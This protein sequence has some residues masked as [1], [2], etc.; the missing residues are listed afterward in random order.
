M[1]TEDQYPSTSDCGTGAEDEDLV[2][3]CLYNAL[4]RYQATPSRSEYIGDGEVCAIGAVWSVGDGED[5]KELVYSAVNIYELR[6]VE[7][8]LKI[9]EYLR[10]EALAAIR[11]LNAAALRLH[12]ECEDDSALASWT[13]P[14]EWVNQSWVPDLGECPRYYVDQDGYEEW[15]RERTA[16][17]YAE[18]GACYKLAIQMR[19]EELAAA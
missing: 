6:G 2:I 8:A 7:L 17:I 15:D 19:R 10:I 5:I 16:K 4:A 12:P 1:S 18:V 14:L 13:G 11:L 9:D 3:V